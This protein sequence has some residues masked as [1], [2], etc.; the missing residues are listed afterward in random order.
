MTEDSLA[1]LRAVDT[2]TICNAI[3]AVEGARRETGFTRHPVVAVDPALPPMVGYARTARIRA[4]EPPDL[5]PDRVRA[6]RLE[7]YE[8]IA[9]GGPTVVAIEDAD[10][11]QPVGAFWGEVNVA[12]HKGFGVAGAITNGLVRDLGMLDPGFQVLASAVGPSHAFVHLIEFDCPVNVFGLDVRPGDL[13]HADRHGAVVVDPA[14]APRLPEGIDLVLRKEKPIL[15][16]ARGPD[17]SVE[18]LRQAWGAAEDVH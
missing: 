1:A 7:Y 4:A 8:Y 5:T 17:F 10:W 11:P 9:V 18:K 14:T 6:M 13:V 2:P 3:E 12:I 16:A 15:D